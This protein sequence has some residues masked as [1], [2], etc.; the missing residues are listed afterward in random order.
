MMVLSAHTAEFGQIYTYLLS[1]PERRFTSP[2]SENPSPWS[3]HKTT[4]HILPVANPSVNI[5]L[6][7]GFSSSLFLL[8][9]FFLQ[10][11]CIYFWHTLP[12]QVWNIVFRVRV[13]SAPFL[14]FCF[15]P[16]TLCIYLWH[17]VNPWRSERNEAFNGLLSICAVYC[18]CLPNCYFCFWSR[19]LSLVQSLSSQ[20]LFLFLIP[21]SVISPE[22][23]MFVF[24]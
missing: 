6:G 20:L 8:F 10:T 9:N 16:Q 15:L 11:L 7:L 2:L 18:V 19:S 23:L 22:S 13:S 5:V 14:V 1:L 17:T 3:S 4:R 21:F 24:F 12:G